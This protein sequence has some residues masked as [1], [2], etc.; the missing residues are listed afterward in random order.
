MRYLCTKHLKF[1]ELPILLTR[2]R[3]YLYL[4]YVNSIAKRL[5]ET[6]TNVVVFGIFY[7]SGVGLFHNIE[8][9]DRGAVTTSITFHIFVIYQVV[10]YKVILILIK[11]SV[12]E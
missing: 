10:L 2:A 4:F 6:I 1:Q 3:R 8:S 5:Y 7:F 12:Y 9:I 11:T